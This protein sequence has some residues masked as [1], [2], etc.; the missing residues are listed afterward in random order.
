MGTAALRPE[1][2]SSATLETG[3]EREKAQALR[4]QNSPTP[5]VASSVALGSRRRGAFASSATVEMT[6]YPAYDSTPRTMACQKA[7]KPP[8]V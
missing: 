2:V 4:A 8:V 5:T 7:E 3:R 1:A 6:S